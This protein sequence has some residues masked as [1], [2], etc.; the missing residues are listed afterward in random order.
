MSRNELSDEQLL[1]QIAAGSP[2]ALEVLYDR[3]AP[4]VLGLALKLTSDQ[5]A[6]EEVVQ[7]TFWRAWRNAHT[8]QTQRGACS[9]WLFGIARNLTIDLYR[10]RKARPQTLLDDASDQR[11]ENVPDPDADVAESVWT[12][13]QHTQVRAAVNSLPDEQ[14][15]VIELAFFAGMTRQEIAEMTGEPLG[16]VHTRARLALKKLREALQSEGFDG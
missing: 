11:F 12:A 3:Y 14:R 1:A 16:T 8:Y 9:S 6:A 2:G 4:A 5:V 13:I 15:Q 7:E 10:R